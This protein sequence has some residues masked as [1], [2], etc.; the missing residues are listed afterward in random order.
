M[1]HDLG[2]FWPARPGSDKTLQNAL[3]GPL[4]A[5]KLTPYLT[6][7]IHIATSTQGWEPKFWALLLMWGPNINLVNE[8]H[9]AYGHT[10]DDEIHQNLLSV[11]HDDGLDWIRTKLTLTRGRYFGPVPVWTR[12]ALRELREHRNFTNRDL[13]HHL[14]AM[15]LRAVNSW[16]GDK[17]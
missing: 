15:Y 3:R 8:I 16:V 4:R 7:E 10:L 17:K 6:R 13:Q 1:L 5:Y 14:G 11:T 9:A 2:A 12:R